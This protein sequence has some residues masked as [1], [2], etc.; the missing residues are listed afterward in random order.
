M[1]ALVQ[2]IQVGG[3]D[4]EQF[5][6]LRPAGA[7]HDF[8]ALERYLRQHRGPVPLEQ[9]ARHPTHLRPMHEAVLPHHEAAYHALWQEFVTVA[10]YQVARPFPI[11]ELD[12]LRGGQQL[13]GEPGLGAGVGQPIAEFELLHQRQELRV[14]VRVYR[15]LPHPCTIGRGEAA[16]LAL[17]GLVVQHLEH[18]LGGPVVL[19]NHSAGQQRIILEMQEHAQVMQIAAQVQGFRAVEFQMSA[20]NLEVILMRNV[21]L[22]LRPLLDVGA[23]GDPLRGQ[24]LADVGQASGRRIPRPPAM[25][26]P[27][28]AVPDSHGKNPSHCRIFP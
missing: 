16:Q 26:P 6:A 21:R 1:E 17:H 7:Q 14:H 25:R 27:P 18:R 5:L 20:V 9:H 2:G 10:Q 13:R 28:R 22:L 23:D 3:D 4:A 12:G 8:A 15:I 11:G 19:Q 24:F